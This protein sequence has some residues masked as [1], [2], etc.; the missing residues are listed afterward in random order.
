MAGV[1]HRVASGGITLHAVTEGNPAGP[2]LVLV[3]GYP[4][5]HR[6]W[7]KVVAALAADYFLVRYDVRGAGQSDK[8]ARTRDY[9]LSCLADDLRAVVDQLLP[10]R[11]FHL[12]AHD[13]GSIQSWESVT[14]APLAGRILSYTSISGPCLD[15]VGFWL[16]R[17]W[18]DVSGGGAGKLL[19]QLASS[20]YVFLFQVPLLPELIWQSGLDRIWPA[21]L[22]RRE[23][24]TDARRTPFQK[25]DGRFGVKLYRANF[26]P[27]L[28]RPAERHATCPVQLLIPGR[29]NYVGSE[30]FEHL[31][32]WTG[33]LTRKE[34]DAPHW[35]PLTDAGLIAEAVR[36]FVS[37]QTGRRALAD[38][39][40]P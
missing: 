5:N 11:P 35:A 3:H 32:H 33:K 24:V 29:D 17:Q 10:D 37:A 8:P 26:L 21:L 9:R 13:W 39:R 14:T 36:E 34:L 1:T 15:H 28:R 25:A 12:V 20:W 27:R 4:D 31:A 38:Q 6:V 7:D 19:R 22:Q 40:V 30:L 2:P 18:R 16:R 23:G